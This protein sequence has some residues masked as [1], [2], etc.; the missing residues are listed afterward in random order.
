MVV[1]FPGLILVGKY[2]VKEAKR[3]LSKTKKAQ[4]LFFMDD[5]RFIKL[6]SFQRKKLARARSNKH[7][8]LPKRKKLSPKVAKKKLYIS[9]FMEKNQALHPNDSKLLRKWF[10]KQIKDI[11]SL[12]ELYSYPL[13]FQE[14]NPRTKDEAVALINLAHKDKD[15]ARLAGIADKAL[16]AAFIN[17]RN[18]KYEKFKL[19]QHGYPF[20][21]KKQVMKVGLVDNTGSFNLYLK[22][23]QIPVAQIKINN[24]GSLTAKVNIAMTHV[25]V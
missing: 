9:S 25:K 8:K 2:G 15:Q 4:D 16:D 13:L 23:M 3:I 17:N 7:L 18:C 22:G 6:V 19:S 14:F 5:K 11:A 10:N 24:N 20:L 1:V 21:E 12:E